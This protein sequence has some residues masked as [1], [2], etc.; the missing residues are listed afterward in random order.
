MASDPEPDFGLG[1]LFNKLD[2]A[3][4]DSVTR[5]LAGFADQLRGDL[6]DGEDFH[7]LETDA[8]YLLSNLC[9]Y[10][11][12]SAEQRTAYHLNNQGEVVFGCQEAAN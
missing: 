4:K 3:F 10:W 7:H 11:G 5:M 2:A 6:D 8:A 9:E 1:R 12:L